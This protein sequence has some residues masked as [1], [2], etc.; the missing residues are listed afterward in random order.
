M[1]LDPLRRLALDAKMRV[2]QARAERFKSYDNKRKNLVN[3]LEE[4]E[5]A[6]KKA[7][8]EKQK[9]EVE[10]WQQTEKIKDEGRRL[11]EEKEKELRSR[12][13]QEE[14]SMKD[15]DVEEAPPSLGL[16]FLVSL[17]TMLSDSLL[18]S[19]DSL[20][21]TV[22]L[23]YSLKTYP[24][25]TSAESIAT[26][27]S[28]FGASD[29]D[30]I[31]IS[32]KPTKKQ[33]D[34][35]PKYGTALVPF[36]QIG[37]AFAAVC[38]SGRKELGLDGVEIAWVGGKEP[39]IL[40]WLKKM[41]KLSTSGTSNPSTVKPTTTSE[42]PYLKN[43]G[44]GGSKADLPLNQSRNKASG[45]SSFPSTF[46]RSFSSAVTILLTGS[47]FSFQPDTDLPSPAEAA[48]STAGIDYE[49]VT[50]MRMRQA[51]RERLE[52]EILEQE[53]NE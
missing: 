8:M 2:K 20:D 36:K 10:I 33:P 34:K 25:L 31:V 38:G 42:S 39:A 49:S 16:Y 44:I 30:S 53:A 48:P 51:E 23:K 19:T 7:R 47:Y 9:E 50:L 22:K 13:K 27:L 24:S 26:L 28:R 11:R 52:R 32:I 29:I 35:P 45:Y 17:F 12:M 18:I 43:A 14:E 3:E 41:G 5:Q 4:R 37:E 6:F 21:T 15:L 46:V 1:L 40:G